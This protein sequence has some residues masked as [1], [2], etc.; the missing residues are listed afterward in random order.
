MSQTIDVGIDLG[1]TNSAV[2]VLRDVTAEVIRNND[3]DQL[4]PSAVWADS[5]DRLHV[6]RR[7]KER[8]R[9]HPDSAC[10]E[11]KLR[12]GSTDTVKTLAGRPMT[13]EALSAEVLRSLRSD[14]AQRLGH[15]PSAAVITV[16]AAF[17]LSACDAT[18]RAAGLAGLKQ[19][20]LLTEPAAAA[21]TYGFQAADEDAM[22][23]VYDL[24]GGTFDAAVIRLV[25]G[26]FS[27]VRHAGDNF[28][29]GKIIDWRIVDELLIPAAR[30]VPGLADLSRG[31]PR[32][33]GAV[34]ALKAAAEAAKV[35]LSRGDGADIEVELMDEDR[36]RHEF[37]YELQRSDIEN[38]ADPV[39]TKSLNLCR[40]ALAGLGMGSDDIAKVVMVGGQ[41]LM[42]YL[43]Q[44]VG[45]ELGIALD[46]DEDPMT[47][48]AR[49][50]AIF[51]GGQ[52]VDQEPAA[53]PSSRG[54][55]SVK[56]AYP[57]VG[58]DADPV[59]MGRVAGPDTALDAL[60]VELVND[61]SQPPWRSGRVR[62]T[63]R[64]H[65]S[66]SLW[67]S[68]G[69]RH[70]YRIELS[71]QTGRMLSVSPGELTYTIGGVETDQT[72]GTTIGVGLDGNRMV[73]LI[74]QGAALPARH[75]V[76]LRTTVTVHR[77]EAGGM[78]RIP[79][80]EGRQSRGD[81]NRRIGRLEVQADQV[82]R[83]VPAGSE[84]RLTIEVDAS[85]LVTASADVPILGEVFDHTIS[86]NTEEAPAFDD[87]AEQAA[88]EKARL[89][90]VRERHL[91][92]GSPLTELYLSR[93]D[94]ERLAEETDDLVR[95]A[96][97]SP[98]DA[99]AA[100]KRIIDLRVAIDA[101][102]DELRWPELVQEAERTVAEAVGLVNT[103]GTERDRE[104]LPAY[105]S[106]IDAAI[107][108]RDPDLLRRR[109]DEMQQHVLRVLDRGPALQ[110]MLF[111]ELSRS[112]G[113]LR[114]PNEAG[115]LIA[116]GNRAIDGGEPER[117][118]AIN[119]QLREHMHEPDIQLNV[120]STVDLFR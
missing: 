77:G 114:N 36:R 81:R 105:A 118:R 37:E 56:L 32:W 39:I 63:D 113:N 88:I 67:A 31:N 51:A 109:I 117:L 93:I 23:L 97:T 61:T 11:F 19:A 72:L 64:G 12:M 59:V 99:L 40:D 10:V 3:G 98:D 62:L 16:P 50:A 18:R 101:A 48:V 1:T 82:A 44:R 100:Q 41:T 70:T 5:R 106:A 95:A 58:P 75:V 119:M 43:R 104:S 4:T 2:A 120:F 34:A 7:A 90:A 26:E 96:R 66:T 116:E 25:D 73:P 6:G 102:E 108:A 14:V 84:I 87:I 79:V 38:L 112:R 52:T 60:S 69:R 21:H 13:P 78:I 29:G 83:T 76:A 94:D 47:V 85:R 9:S 45:A 17:D 107:E 49:G 65:F 20:P 91:A 103:E 74:R 30:R 71:D 55:Y 53:A 86:L 46:F 54:G 22:W 15:E 27:V 57:R 42:P 35:Q 111:H 115:R 33:A 92:A 24:G 68:R 80:L 28:L 89:A 110:I 8:S